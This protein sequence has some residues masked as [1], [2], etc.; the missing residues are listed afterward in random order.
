MPR[1][2][3][4]LPATEGRVHFPVKVVPVLNSRFPMEP[5]DGTGPLGGLADRNSSE[6]WLAWID[7]GGEG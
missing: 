5:A 3:H 4:N 2:A 7:L 6:W 1:I